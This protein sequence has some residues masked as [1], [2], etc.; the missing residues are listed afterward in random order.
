MCVFLLNLLSFLFVCVLE[1]SSIFRA[2]CFRSSCSTTECLAE[3]CFNGWYCEDAQLVPLVLS[4]NVL[5][6]SFYIREIGI[7]A[8][9][10]NHHFEISFV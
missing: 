1:P 6:S 7:S 3:E 9:Y 4:F 10:C 2:C 8:F 5:A